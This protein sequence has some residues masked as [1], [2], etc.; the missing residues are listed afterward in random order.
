MG[1]QAGRGGVAGAGGGAALQALGGQGAGLPVPGEDFAIEDQADRWLRN[2]RG[3]AGERVLD[4]GAAVGLELHA[5]TRT[6][7]SEHEQ[8]VPVELGLCAV[9][10]FASRPRGYAFAVP[11]AAAGSGESM[12]S[13]K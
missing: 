9:G 7:Q 1:R 5:P 11:R 12:S 13:M 6:V 8:P 3:E 4:R 2:R 10:Q